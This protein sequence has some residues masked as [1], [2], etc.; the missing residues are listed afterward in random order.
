MDK[1]I[2]IIVADDHVV[3]REGMR[4][5]LTRDPRFDVVETAADAVTLADA[6]DRVPCDFV[7]SDVGMRG[8][9]GENNAIALL[10]RVL[11]HKPRPH[12]IVV[13]MIAQAQMLAGLLQAGVEGIV[14]KRDGMHALNEAIDAILRGEC[15]ASA[16]ASALLGDDP[17]AMPARAGVLSAREWEVFQLYASGLPVA[18]IAQRLGRSSKTIGTQKRNGM[19]KLGLETE[20]DL[21]GYL[22]QIGLA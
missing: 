19:R 11:R 9:N 12:V 21:V 6:L 10:R 8:M 18:S 22:R 14:D 17:F 7:I 16:H 3:V 13:T 1:K 5:W 4:I 20:H 2:K 15:F